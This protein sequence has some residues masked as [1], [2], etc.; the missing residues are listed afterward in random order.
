MGHIDTI[1]EHLYDQLGLILKLKRNFKTL[2]NV[3]VLG[4]ENHLHSYAMALN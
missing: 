3:F 2:I 4:Q 1:G